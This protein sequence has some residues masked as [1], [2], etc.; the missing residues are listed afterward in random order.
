MGGSFDSQLTLNPACLEEL[1]WWVA[2]L[3]AWNSRASLTPAPDLVIETDASMLGWGAVCEG[4]RIGG[5][6]SHSEQLYHI[7][8]LQLLAGAFTVRCFSKGK[9]CLHVHLKMDNTT[10]VA[11]I[12]KVRGGT[13]PCTMQ[14]CGQP[15]ELGPRQRHDPQCRA[16]AWEMEHPGRPRIEAL[17][18]MILATRD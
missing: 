17:S 5:L 1:H 9:I 18:Y 3:T 6:W 2:H 13:L 12:N 7:N 10:A 16:P 11:Y 14:P 8:C 4:V 15:V